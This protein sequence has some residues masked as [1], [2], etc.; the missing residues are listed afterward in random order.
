MKILS[1]IIR[2]FVF[3]VLFGLAI[4]NSTLVDLKF[5]FDRTWQMPL[6]LVIL[7]AFGVGTAFGLTAVLATLVRQRRE[8]GKLRRLHEAGKPL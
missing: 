8:L 6:S 4:K 2:A 3:I 7:I 1:W 5:F